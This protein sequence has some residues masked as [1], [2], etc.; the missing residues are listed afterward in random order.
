MIFF[1]S[2]WKQPINAAKN[3]VSDPQIVKIFKISG[4]Y[5]KI[6]D[7]LKIKKIPAVTIVAA[8]IKADTGVGPSIASGNHICKINCADLLTAPIIKNQQI[9]FKILNLMPKK[10]K[11]LIKKKKY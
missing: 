9:K 4:A 3:A 11:I 2:D 8:W 10:K 1:I 7:V 5:S 6:K